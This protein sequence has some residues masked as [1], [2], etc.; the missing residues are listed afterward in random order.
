MWAPLPVS[1]ASLSCRGLDTRRNAHGNRAGGNVVKHDSV[2]ADPCTITDLYRAQ[3]TG[4]CTYNDVVPD[5]GHILK[6]RPA[7]DRDIWP[8]DDVVADLGTL[9]YNDSKAG[10]AE[11]DIAA[12]CCTWRQYNRKQYPVEDVDDS[13]QEGDPA[14]MKPASNSIEVDHGVSK[15][16]NA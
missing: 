10:I 4:A 13:R 5:D 3:N 12:N 7:A 15:Y 14:Q 11:G 1:L 8:D 9:M 16:A 2:G 6:T